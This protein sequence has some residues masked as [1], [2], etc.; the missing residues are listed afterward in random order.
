MSNTEW[1]PLNPLVDML[2]E[3]LDALCHQLK[4]IVENLED[5]ICPEWSS[6]IDITNKLH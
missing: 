5:L 1:V 6:A 2:V 4:N 3:E